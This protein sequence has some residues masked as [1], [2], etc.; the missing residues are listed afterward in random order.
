MIDEVAF[1]HSEEYLKGMQTIDTMQSTC[2]E[3]EFSGDNEKGSMHVHVFQSDMTI[4]GLFD[5]GASENFISH[6]FLAERDLLY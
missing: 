5:G 2:A 3:T 1:Q 6:T 4:V